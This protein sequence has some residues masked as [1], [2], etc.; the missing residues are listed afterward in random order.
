[1]G[2]Y[3]D[4]KFSYRMPDGYKGENYQTKDFDLT[5][6]G[7][8]V[9]PEGRLVRTYDSGYPDDKRKRPLGDLNYSGTLNI[10]TSDLRRAW[11]EYDL[12]FENGNLVAIHCHQTGGRL[13]FEPNSQQVLEAQ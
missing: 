11:H 12:E 9:T 8:E 13:L 10:Y 1:M 7:Y 4:V 6:D 3:D 5:L 2:M